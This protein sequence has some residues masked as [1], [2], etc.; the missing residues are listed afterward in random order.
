M[1]LYWESTLRSGTVGRS[2]LQLMRGCGPCAKGDHATATPSQIFSKE[3]YPTLQRHFDVTQ[4]F[5][6]I[7][8]IVEFQ[9]SLQRGHYHGGYLQ[10]VHVCPF[11]GLGPSLH[12]QRLQTC[13][14][15]WFACM[16]FQQPLDKIFLDHFWT[17]LL[18]QAGTQ[19]KY[20]S[21][22]DPQTDGQTE[23]TNRCLDAYLCYYV[24]NTLV[25]ARD[26]IFEQLHHNL[27]LAQHRIKRQADKH[28]RDVHLDIGDWVY[29]KA[30]PY[31]WHLLAKHRNKKLSPQFYVAYRLSLPKSCQIHP[32]FHVS[33]LKKVVPANYQPQ[34][35]L[36]TLT[37]NWVLQPQLEDIL[38]L[39]YNKEGQAVL[40]KWINLPDCE[41]S[42]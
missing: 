25:E 36:V 30:S 27:T 32:V 15:R 33:K 38:A 40:A 24:A 12:S 10:I 26:T 20:S 2:K 13:S 7:P 18:K 6:K 41:N 1:Q 11:S 21:A 35:L 14:L 22:F 9:S 37:A 28:R 8:V 5:S 39:H 4:E 19:L 31:K 23:V 3:R 42:W 29:F 17:E 16:G 34:P